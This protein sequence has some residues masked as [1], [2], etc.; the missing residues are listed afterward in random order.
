MPLDQRDGYHLITT[1]S[2]GVSSFPTSQ[3]ALVD[4]MILTSG[5]GPLSPGSAEVK[6]KTFREQVKQTI[7][8]IESVL[9]EAGSSLEHI[10]R[11][12]IFL[13]NFEDFDEFNKVYAELMP[14]PLPP[15]ACVI[16]NLVRKD[17]DVE[18][19]ANAVVPSGEGR[20]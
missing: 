17:I 5:H 8:N 2:A 20:A 6:A 19:I 9:K 13:R 16:A 18:M 3:G 12:Q 1:Q 14:R 10:V 15:R 7:E 4:N 11:M